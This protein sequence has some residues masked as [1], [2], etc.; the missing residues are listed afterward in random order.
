MVTIRNLTQ[1]I[2]GKYMH[3]LNNAAKV[4]ALPTQIDLI[5]TNFSSDWHQGLYTIHKTQILIQKLKKC[6]LESMIDAN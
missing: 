5:C 2:I 4:A 6:K 1:D 3:K